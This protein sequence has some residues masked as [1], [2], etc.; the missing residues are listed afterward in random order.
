MKVKNFVPP[1]LRTVLLEF[2]EIIILCLE[3]FHYTLL[4]WPSVE[5]KKSFLFSFRLTILALYFSF[6]VLFFV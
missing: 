6:V 5:N 2:L 3:F 4:F 1:F